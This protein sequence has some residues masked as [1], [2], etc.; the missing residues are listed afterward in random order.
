MNVENTVMSGLS[1]IHTHWVHL[2]K[3]EICRW[4]PYDE[5]DPTDACFSVCV[6]LYRGGSMAL[7][8]Y[9]LYTPLFPAQITSQ[10]LTFLR[11]SWLHCTFTLLPPTLVFAFAPVFGRVASSQ[12][13][14]V[15]HFYLY[16]TVSSTCH[17]SVV[18]RKTQQVKLL[19]TPFISHTP[20]TQTHR[21]SETIFYSNVYFPK[22]C[23]QQPSCT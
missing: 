20:S 13:V 3:P 2:E 11:S 4:G 22:P 6:V 21:G 9:T 8:K 7:W 16:C 14:L 18:Y 15:W 19:Q 1:G 12:L 23:F 17:K 10:Y 5:C